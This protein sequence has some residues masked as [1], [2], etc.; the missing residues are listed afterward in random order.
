MNIK[1]VGI[2]KDND[3]EAQN[4]GSAVF[5]WNEY[6]EEEEIRLMSFMIDQNQNVEE[7]KNFTTFVLKLIIKKIS[8]KPQNSDT[9]LQLKRTKQYIT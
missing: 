4:V 5:T 6:V 7:V 9:R 3:Q 8:Q 1:I 2:L